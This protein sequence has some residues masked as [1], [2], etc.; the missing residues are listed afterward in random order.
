MYVENMC[1]SVFSLLQCEKWSIY[2][3]YVFELVMV[4]LLAVCNVENMLV[5]GAV[6]VCG[7]CYMKCS[8][9]VCICLYG[10]CVWLCVCLHDMAW[11]SLCIPLEPKTKHL[12]LL[13]GQLP[14]F[15]IPSSGSQGS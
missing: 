5:H 11:P 7:M 15:P 8:L 1:V 9:L 14:R 2:T 4:C 10:I 12:H 13:Q 3:W 6:C